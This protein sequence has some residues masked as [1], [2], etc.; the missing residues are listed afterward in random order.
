[1]NNLQT[2]ITNYLDFCQ[3]QKRLDKKTL[4]A[5]R[6][7]LRQ[8]SSE[9]EIDNVSEITTAILEKYVTTLHQSYKPKTVKRKIAS[10]KAFF[11]HL[12][13]RDILPASPF[14]KMQIKFREPVILPKTIPLHTIQ[15]LLSAMY[16]YRNH[17]PTPYQSKIPYL[18]TPN[19]HPAKQS[20]YFPLRHVP[21]TD[22]QPILHPSSIQ[23]EKCR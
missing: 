6:I 4:K 12:E 11:R 1:M 21:K 14:N 7:D 23:T 2:T 9:L 8:F 3:Y 20:H 5:Y 16:F 18:H 22:N 17:A 19:I 10:L 13:Y 15:S